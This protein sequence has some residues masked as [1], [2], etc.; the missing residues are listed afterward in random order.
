MAVN[1]TQTKYFQNI[2]PGGNAM[3]FSTLATTMGL[4]TAGGVRLGAYIRKTS[5]N[6]VFADVDAGTVAKA[7]ATAIV[8]DS[9]E[10]RT[11][12]V[13]GNGIPDTTSNLK[14]SSFKNMIKRWD[15]SYT[16]GS[17]S[18]VDISGGGGVIGGNWAS[19]LDLNV[20]KRVNFDGSTWKASTVNEH[21]VV[22]SGSALNLDMTF[23]ATQVLGK[24]GTGGAG[25][26][27]NA[28]AT[29]GNPGGGALYL[30]NTT[31]RTTGNASTI[32][33]NL[34]NT[35]LISGGGGGGGGGPVGNVS[36]STICSNYYIYTSRYTYDWWY[37][38]PSSC[39][40]G[41]TQ[42]ACGV[43][44]PEAPNSYSVSYFRGQRAQGTW[45]Y[46]PWYLTCSGGNTYTYG[47]A[48]PA[49]GGGGGI[50]QGS[51]NVAGPAAG[52]S[53][54]N[55]TSLNCPAGTSSQNSTST[56]TVGGSGGSG[57]TFG[58]VGGATNVANGGNPGPWLNVSNTRWSNKGASGAL[59]QRT[60]IA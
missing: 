37:G 7:N 33:L 24:E 4:P 34:S 45:Y 53:P 44:N 47:T 12:G 49:A 26:T 51:N 17:N 41:E 22:F 57:G 18:Q 54:G 20:P 11:C 3:S 60:N 48:P 25:Q 35:A 32:N 50:G 39:A 46:T 6:E 58:S 2:G 31:N 15:V 56:G 9:I 30:R 59:V 5:A 40:A 1:I 8:P 16:G 13:D 28:A 23:P 36:G 21:A 52:N 42:N 27:N 38:C 55:E 29:N 10:N 43:G 19:N 14:I